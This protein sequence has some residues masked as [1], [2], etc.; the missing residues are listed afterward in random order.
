V[1]LEEENGEKI[2]LLKEIK[3]SFLK[4]DIDES[5]ISNPDKFYNLL[6]LLSEQAGN[7]F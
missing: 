5:G 7:L 4:R 1:V 2:N 6:S 3:N